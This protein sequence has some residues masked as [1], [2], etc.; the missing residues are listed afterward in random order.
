MTP[1]T[2][3]P[4]VRLFIDSGRNHNM[5]VRDLISSIANETH[6][7]DTQIGKVRIFDHYAFVEVPADAAATVT[8]APQATQLRGVTVTITRG[9]PTGQRRPSGSRGRRLTGTRR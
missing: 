1:A 3:G 9:T 2:T 5:Q 7:A 4:P 6:L 8:A